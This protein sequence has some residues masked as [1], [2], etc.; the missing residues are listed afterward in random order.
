MV[1]I[2]DVYGSQ[3]AAY[4]RPVP[5]STVDN[6]P[7]TPPPLAKPK[8][9]R[10]QSYKRGWVYSVTWEDPDWVWRVYLEAGDSPVLY[11]E[12]RVLGLSMESA[13][14]QSARD[15]IDN[16]MEMHPE[17]DDP[18]YPHSM[19]DCETGVEYIAHTLADHQ[20]YEA[21]GYVHSM[22]ECKSENGDDDDSK[23]EYAILGGLV[24][25]ALAMV[26]ILGDDSDG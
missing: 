24:L 15:W 13:A 16:Y 8:E 20:K 1:E 3:S 9:G 17:P 7:Q 4:N 23:Y 2:S 11:Q 25:I 12:G 10:L 5:V 14:A 19:W 26:F 22:D 18:N 6:S 21:L